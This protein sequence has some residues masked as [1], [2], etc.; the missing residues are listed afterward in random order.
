M[1]RNNRRS[2]FYSSLTG[3]GLILALHFL[4]EYGRDSFI[5]ITLGTSLLLIFEV[6]LDWRYATRILRQ[7]DMPTVNVYNLWGNLLNHITLPLFLYYSFAGFIYFNED[8][9]IRIVGIFILTII[10]IILFMNIRS[11]YRDEFIIE[12][13]THYIYS[14]IKLITFFFG[15]NLILHIMNFW[16][17]DNW[18]YSLLVT[19][20]SLILGLLLI[21]RKQDQSFGEFVYVLLSSFVIGVVFLVL[22]TINVVFLG[23]NII[24]FLCFYIALSTLI[25]RLERTLSREIF[26]EYIL[27]LILAIIL[28]LGIS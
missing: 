19:L 21:Y 17:V 27:I 26:V 3:L 24:V 18:F 28:F 1:I 5:I 14:I 11:Y 10:N 22:N 16:V 15:V 6:Y 7:I 9:L 25:H 2:I 12:E 23:I 4:K 20:L 13:K 8:D